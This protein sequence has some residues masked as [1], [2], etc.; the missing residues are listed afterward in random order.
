MAY[1]VHLFPYEKFTSAYINFVNRHFEPGQHRFIVYGSYP[2]VELKLENTE[3]VIFVQQLQTFLLSKHKYPANMLYSADKIL[4]HSLAGPAAQLLILS[5][6]LWGKLYL[7][8]W[9]YEIYGFR[10]K[11]PGLREALYRRSIATIAKHARAILTLMHGDAEVL[12]R[13]VPFK[14]RHLTIS[15]YNEQAL[16]SW[17]AHQDA[18][19]QTEPFLFLLGNNAHP[20]NNHDAVLHQLAAYKGK[21]F[22]VLAPL[23]YGDDAN[24][25]RVAALGKQL[26]GDA[27]VPLMDLMKPE[28]YYALLSRCS[29]AFFNN[30]RQQAIGNIN[31]LICMGAKLYL[32]PG[33]VMWEEFVVRRHYKLFDLSAVGELPFESLLEYDSADYHDILSIFNSYYSLD[34]AIAAWNAIFEAT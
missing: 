18:P 28:D 27:F 23:S 7:L 26:L 5:P 19:K 6:R 29:V 16:A 13:Y 22:Q 14:G 11:R 1:I 2:G 20:S 8:F 32:R 21:P 31:A 33:T 25:R 12:R 34:G 4:V 24:A 30:D 10:D 9:G 15:Y 17:R 3:N